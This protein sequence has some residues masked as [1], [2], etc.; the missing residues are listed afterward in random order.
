MDK[1]N[2][3]LQLMAEGKLNVIA[4]KSK[5]LEMEQIRIKNFT[6]NFIIS[7]LGIVILALLVF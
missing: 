4:S 1:A 6:N 7:F 3:A 5:R 2:Y